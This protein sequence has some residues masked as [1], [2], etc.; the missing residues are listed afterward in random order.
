MVRLVAINTWRC[1]HLVS[2]HRICQTIRRQTGTQKVSSCLPACSA[3]ALHFVLP[4]QSVSP[5][6]QSSVRGW[7]RASFVVFVLCWPL[8]APGRQSVSPK[9][10]PSVRLAHSRVCGKGLGV[11]RL[12]L[13]CL[14]TWGSLACCSPVALFRC[15]WG[16]AMSAWALLAG[17]ALLGYLWSLVFFCLVGVAGVLV[18]P[19]LVLG[20]VAFSGVFPLC[21]VWAPWV[22]GY[23]RSLAIGRFP[24]VLGY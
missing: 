6:V 21:L 2:G 15:A 3:L 22:L 1:C 23:L 24:C 19:G 14:V 12:R 20:V 10:L 4:C 16:V 9:V 8:T 11:P 17:L 5:K 7:D 18:V 13:V